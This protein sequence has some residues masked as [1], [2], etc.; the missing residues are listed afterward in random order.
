[1]RSA[2]SA[3]LNGDGALGKRNCIRKSISRSSRAAVARGL[4]SPRA[5]LSAVAANL[6]AEH[7]FIGSG[8]TLIT[9][10]VT[11][12]LLPVLTPIDNRNQT[13][14]KVAAGIAAVITDKVSA[15]V[16]AVCTFARADG[17][18]FGVNDGLKVTF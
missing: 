7:D 3:G 5:P 10:Q 2:K 8:R 12:A 6:T 16:D 15:T 9:T 13:Y 14:G 17:N 4:N 11:T 18:D 1:M